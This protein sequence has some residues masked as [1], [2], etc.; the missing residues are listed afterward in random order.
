MGAATVRLA[1]QVAENALARLGA[2]RARLALPP[3]VPHRD[4][5]A[6]ALRALAGLALAAGTVL[7]FPVT[8]PDAAR[9]AQELMDFAWHE[10]RDGA[11]LHQIQRDTPAATRP[12]EL[13]SRFA[14]AGYRHAGLDDLAAHLHG[15]R[16]ARVTELAPHRRLAVLAATRRLGLPDPPDAAE[17]TRRTW[18]GGTPEP[19]MLDRTHA[20]ALAH[21]VLHLTDWAAHPHA[22]PPD[23]ADYTDRWLPVWTETFA[24]THSWDLV[25]ELLAAGACLPRPSL[26]HALWPRLAE[27]QHPDGTLTTGPP[28]PQ[29]DG[30][31][32]SDHHHPTVVAVVAGTLTVLR[33]LDTVTDGTPP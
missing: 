11:L 8:G 5:P 23:L 17:L 13:Y 21:T 6:A 7:R 29:D 26:P 4:I 22:L 19:W 9:T 14:A 20:H 3:G 1:H 2:D 28:T 27:A 18:L 16:A 12:V 32:P 33:A 24:G 30:D 10:L 31:P 25:C 15:L